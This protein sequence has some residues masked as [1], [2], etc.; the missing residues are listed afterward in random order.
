MGE[1]FWFVRKWSIQLRAENKRN[2]SSSSDFMKEFA[3]KACDLGLRK[4]F[5]EKCGIMQCIK[6][7]FSGSV[8]ARKDSVP[9]W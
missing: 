2:I 9:A 1:V 6:T 5:V 7:I 8:T 3:E 4:L